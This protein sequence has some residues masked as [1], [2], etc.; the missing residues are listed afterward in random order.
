MKTLLIVSEESILTGNIKCGMAELVSSLATA[1]TSD[2]KV[3][4]LTP[5][6]AG[7]LPKLLTH[8]ED[9]GDY[10]DGSF[11]KVHYYLYRTP[12]A[13]LNLLNSLEY[14]IFHNFDEP[15]LITKLA[16]TPEK[17]IYTFETT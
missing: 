5:D 15:E 11:L 16:R 8:M 1:L 17:T 13:K 7:L 12:E 4:V 14:D 6:G 2:Y 9:H 3:L 10:R